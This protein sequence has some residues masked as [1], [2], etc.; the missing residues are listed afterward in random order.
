MSNIDKL[1]ELIQTAEKK[2]SALNNDIF[3]LHEYLKG[4][5][6]ARN[7]FD[8]KITQKAVIKVVDK[9]VPAANEGGNRTERI[10]ALLNDYPQG[11]SPTEISVK[12]GD[13]RTGVRT[14]L[15]NCKKRGSLTNQNGR[16]ILPK[17]IEGATKL[18]S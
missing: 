8:E 17:F 15:F 3:K 13:S 7:L 6:D 11:L 1:D 10:F 5:R 9:I 2:I 4:L 12:L 18:A 14:T 16:Y